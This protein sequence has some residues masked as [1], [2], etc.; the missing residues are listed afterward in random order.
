MQ[1]SNRMPVLLT[2]PLR[3][4]VDSSV[5]AKLSERFN[6][7]FDVTM[8]PSMPERSSARK[9]L[10][11]RPGFWQSPLKSVDDV[12][13]PGTGVPPSPIGWERELCYSRAGIFILI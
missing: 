3:F 10:L 11:V 12:P 1:M 4:I 6:N 7:G 5:P 13:S 9:G 8:E 2:V